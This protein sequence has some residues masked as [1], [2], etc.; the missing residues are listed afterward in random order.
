MVAVGN[1]PKKDESLRLDM[2]SKINE[3]RHWFKWRGQILISN[4]HDRE[5]RPV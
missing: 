3:A 5:R 2:M 1:G 4:R